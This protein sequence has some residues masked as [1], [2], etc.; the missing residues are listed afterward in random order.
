VFS[1]WRQNCR[2]LSQKSPDMKKKKIQKELIALYQL[3]ETYRMRAHAELENLK[4][5]DR[6][7]RSL[8]KLLHPPAN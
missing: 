5:T 3:R 8:E 6:E 4:K 2:E 7:I 1:V